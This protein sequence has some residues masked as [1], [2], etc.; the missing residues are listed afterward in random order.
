[1]NEDDTLPPEARSA[2]E[3]YHAMSASKSEYFGLLQELDVKYRERGSP[4]VAENLKLEKLLQAHGEKVASFNNAMQ[5][6]TDKNTRELLLKKLMAGAAPP[7][8][9]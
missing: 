5:A 3:A 9:E 8:A 4:T 1:M 7:T 2:L 6:V